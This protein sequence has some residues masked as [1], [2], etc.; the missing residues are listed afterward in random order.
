VISRVDRYLLSE[1]IPQFFLWLCII[2]GVLV[3]SQLVRLTDVLSNFGFSIE[4]ILLPF[5][6]IIFPFLSL[7][8]P[9][10]LLFA[11][12]IAFSRLS[13][14]GEYTAL[15]ANGIS[16]RRMMRPVF[17]GAIVLY[18]ISAFSALNLEP[19]GRRELMNFYERKAQTELDNL[20]RYRL[21]SGVFVDNFLGFVLYAE[22]VSKDRQKLTNVLMAPG[23][24]ILISKNFS[25]TAP[26]AYVHGS[27]EK[28]NLTMEFKKGN[29][30]AQ[31]DSGDS[32]VLRFRRGEIDMIGLFEQQVFGGGQAGLDHRNLGPAELWASVQELKTSPAGQRNHL[33]S[34]ISYLFHQRVAGSFSLFFFV[35]VGVVL[36]V[37]DPRGGKAGVWSWGI[38]A[39]LGNYLIAVLFR[40][41]AHNAYLPSEI[42][43]WGPCLILALIGLVM[44]WQRNRLPISESIFRL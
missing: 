5:V 15:L 43:A 25:L 19:W 4:N 10:A 11:V 2:S 32:S 35:M 17:G 14:D 21:Q 12:M 26:E 31:T 8:I 3:V 9:M 24:N 37:Q 41:T 29:V 33:Y 16:L 23:E 40:W 1:L 38:L 44:I 34:K 30:I 7:T 20:V 39:L 36:G 13:A 22:T 6:F 42:A 28:R 18:F 27:V